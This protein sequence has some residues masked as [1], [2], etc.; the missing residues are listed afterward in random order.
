MS[1]HNAKSEPVAEPESDALWGAIAIGRFI[2]RSQSQVYYLHEAGVFGDAVR[3]VSRK[4]L[5]GSKS[6]L[7]RFVAGGP[8]E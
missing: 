6:R 2:G 4:I 3:K 8:G 7:S 1:S 5:L